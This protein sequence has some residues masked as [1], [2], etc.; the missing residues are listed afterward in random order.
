[1]TI[2][3]RMAIFA[4]TAV[5]ASAAL[6]VAHDDLPRRASLGFRL[7]PPPEGTSGATV[8]AVLPGGS[9]EKMGVKANDRVVALNGAA[10]ASTAELIAAGQKIDGGTPLTLSIVRNGKAITLK[11]RAITRPLEPHPGFAVDYGSFA[12]RDNRLRDILISP[13][14]RD[15]FPV[16]FL[17]PG[18]SCGTVESPDPADPYRRLGDE[19]LTRGIAYYRFDRVGVGDSRGPLRC[20]DIDH[21]VE[22]DAIRAAYRHLV[23]DRKIPAE[24]VFFFGHSLGGLQAPIIAAERAPRGVAV[25]GTVVRNWADYHHDVDATQPFLLSGFDPVDQDAEA[26]RNRDL[27][28]MFYFER[29]SPTQIVAE[30][31]EYGDVL[32]G[33]F[34]WD[35]GTHTFGRSYVLNQQLA[36]LPLAKAWKDSKTNVLA[37]Y[38]ASDIVALTDIDHRMLADWINEWRPGTGT[39][40]E[41]ADTDHGMMLSGSRV[42]MRA[43]NRTHSR[44]PLSFNPKVADALAEWIRA[45]MAKPPVG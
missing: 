14:N 28:R 44:P 24:R 2:A 3:I 40:V 19:L 13:P 32:R 35:G 16:V 21:D 34:G 20:Q 1:M 5:S 18:Y 42:E 7:A 22:L 17:M 9:G 29:K 43:Q 8:S 25:Y 23:D 41:V 27:F 15:D 38:G 26:E 10:I 36:H 31:P 11:G 12:F 33:L 6:A 39:F 45:C 4:A 37:L 30:R